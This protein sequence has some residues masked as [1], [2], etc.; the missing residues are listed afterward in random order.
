[1]VLLAAGTI[2]F[3]RSPRGVRRQRWR[4]EV[5][6]VRLT[7]LKRK[8]CDQLPLPRRGED[9]TGT[10]VSETRRGLSRGVPRL[11]RQSVRRRR[12]VRLGAVEY[13]GEFRPD[14]QT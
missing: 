8:S 7:G 2:G 10:D 13:I 9:G 3:R 14:L 11:R 6:T 4:T 1:M 12:I 5:A